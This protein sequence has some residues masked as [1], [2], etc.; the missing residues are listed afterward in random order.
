MDCTYSIYP[1]RAGGP[2]TVIDSSDRSLHGFPTRCEAL[3]FAH[4]KIRHN[5]CGSIHLVR[6]A[7]PEVVCQPQRRVISQNPTLSGAST[8]AE[9]ALSAVV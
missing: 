4:T 7:E 2:W 8:T 3:K 5:R 9:R 1:P 6:L